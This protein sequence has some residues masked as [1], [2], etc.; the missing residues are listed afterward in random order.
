MRKQFNTTA[1]NLR[2]PK[3]TLNNWKPHEKPRMS[4]N[5]LENLRPLKKKKKITTLM[6]KN[7][8]NNLKTQMKIRILH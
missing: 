5:A 8:L 4:K 2:M 7:A 1:P 3:N 6:L